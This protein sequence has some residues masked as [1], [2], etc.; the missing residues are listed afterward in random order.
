MVVGIPIRD[1]R[2]RWFTKCLPAVAQEGGRCPECG[3]TVRSRQRIEDGLAFTTYSDSS[4]R[5]TYGCAS[6]PGFDRLPL[7][8]VCGVVTR[9][10]AVSALVQTLF[11]QMR[12]G[13]A[14][15]PEHPPPPV[16]RPAM[17]Q[18]LRACS[19]HDVGSDTD[20]HVSST[21]AADDDEHPPTDQRHSDSDPDNLARHP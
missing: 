19:V 13:W 21:G 10:L 18:A 4:T 20:A 14:V 11:K 15:V 17:H 12:D 3:S 1:E 9:N 5:S 8:K 16:P 2:K 6:A 7:V